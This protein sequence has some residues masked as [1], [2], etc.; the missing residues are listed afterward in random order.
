MESPLCFVRRTSMGA[1]Q[2]TQAKMN[3]LLKHIWYTRDFLSGQGVLVSLYLQ[4]VSGSWRNAATCRPFSTLRSLACL[5]AR[6]NDF[7][8][9]AVNGRWNLLRHYMAFL[10]CLHGSTSN[11]NFAALIPWHLTC[12]S[13]QNPNVNLPVTRHGPFLSQKSQASSS[14]P[15]SFAKF[16][17]RPHLWLAIRY[18]NRRKSQRLSWKVYS[19]IES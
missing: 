19:A 8:S 14:L 10:Q 1:K 16:W 11:I 9:P 5:V 2:R 3:S 17:E 15:R 4:P 7:V 6:T 13:H 12:G 18:R